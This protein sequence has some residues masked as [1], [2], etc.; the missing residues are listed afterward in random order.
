M[1]L[2]KFMADENERLQS[3]KHLKDK[4]PTPLHLTQKKL[5]HILWLFILHLF[6]YSSPSNGIFLF[7]ESSIMSLKEQFTPIQTEIIENTKIPLNFLII[8][9]PSRW[10]NIKDTWDLYSVSSNSKECFKV[11]LK[12]QEILKIQMNWAA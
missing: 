10:I 5:Q 6:P 11:I 12:S 2:L 7:Y 1:F 4:W 3:S 9:F 8:N